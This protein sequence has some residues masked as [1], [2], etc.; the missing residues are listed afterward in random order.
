MARLR[1]GEKDTNSIKVHNLLRWHDNGLTEQEMSEM[2]GMDRRR[3][4]NYLRELEEKQKAY[5]ERRLWFA[6]D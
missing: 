6:D 4:N 5:R 1:A 2:I 3:L